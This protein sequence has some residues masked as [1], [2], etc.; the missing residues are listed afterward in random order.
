MKYLQ[1]IRMRSRGFENPHLKGL[2][3]AEFVVEALQLNDELTTECT[4]ELCEG[5]C[6]FYI[7]IIFYKVGNL[8]FRLPK[9]IRYVN[10]KFGWKVRVRL[11]QDSTGYCK[12]LYET[13]YARRLNG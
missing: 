7:K 4:Q 6:E 5:R 12:S 8:F 1:H 13:V 2:S 9:V 3:V 11:K 10:N